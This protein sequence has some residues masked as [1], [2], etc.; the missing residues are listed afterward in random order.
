LLRRLFVSFVSAAVPQC[1]YSA[2]CPPLAVVLRAGFK[3]STQHQY[4]KQNQNHKTETYS[5]IQIQIQIHTQILLAAAAS[6]CSLVLRFRIFRIE[7]LLPNTTPSSTSSTDSQT[8][9]VEPPVGFNGFTVPSSACWPTNSSW[10]AP[11]SRRQVC[12]A[13]KITNNK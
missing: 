12:N 3:F 8:I 1:E 7:L 10:P 2:L 11:Y 6:G 4:H 5:R 13:V 9:L